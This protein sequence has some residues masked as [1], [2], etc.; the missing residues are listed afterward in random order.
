MKCPLKLPVILLYAI[1]HI[2]EINR[3]FSGDFFSYLNSWI[4]VNVS[5]FSTLKEYN[6]YSSVRVL[7]CA[8]PCMPFY[9]Y[10]CV[11]AKNHNTS[12]NTWRSKYVHDLLKIK[13]RVLKS[14]K[15]F[16]KHFCLRKT[17]YLCVVLGCCWLGE[18]WRFALNQSSISCSVA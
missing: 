17:H 13:Q 16:N 10:E 2:L 8:H 18:Q 4:P 9:I 6:I 1:D 12:I 15:L 11:Y 14:W 7:V 3:W 5:S